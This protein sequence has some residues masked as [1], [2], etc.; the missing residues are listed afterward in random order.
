MN[1]FDYKLA[2]LANIN[3]VNCDDAKSNNR[4]DGSLPDFT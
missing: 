3:Y 1:C 4:R 2:F